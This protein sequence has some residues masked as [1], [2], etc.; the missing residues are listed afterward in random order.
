MMMQ[1][2]CSTGSVPK[3][4]EQCRSHDQGDEGRPDPGELPG[5][6]RDDHERSRGRQT[7]VELSPLVPGHGGYAET[8]RSSPWSTR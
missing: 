3:R 4:D 6:P 2:A 8:P 1:R 7:E 5:D